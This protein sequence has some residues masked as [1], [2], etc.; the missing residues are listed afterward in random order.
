MTNQPIL[1]DEEVVRVYRDADFR[2]SL[3][4][5]QLLYANSHPA[6]P[7]DAVHL[8]LTDADLDSVAGGAAS[9]GSVCS[10]CTICSWCDIFD[11]R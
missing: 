6:A 8:E 11:Q 7:A 10:V 2:D 5:E 9:I 1:T 4:P 3:T